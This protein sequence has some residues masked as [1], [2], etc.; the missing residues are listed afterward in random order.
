MYISQL[1]NTI[2]GTKDGKML[3]ILKKT[4]KEVEKEL[5]SRKT[6]EGKLEE[7]AKRDYKAE[8]KKYGSSTKSKKYRAELNKY[9]RKKGTYGNGDGKDASHKGGKI[10]GFEKESVNRGRREKSRLKKEQKLREVIRDILSEISV[11]SADWILKGVGKGGLKKIVD[12]SKKNKD[13]TYLVTDDNY[14]HIGN[15]YLRNGKFA[16]AKTWGNPNY[17]FQNNKTNLRA[18]SDVIYK[19]RVVSEDFAGAYPEHQ[20]KKFDGKRRKQSEILGYKLT[21]KSDVK[22][23]I[24]DATVNEARKYKVIDLRSDKGFKEAEKLQKQGWKVAEVGFHKI[25]MVKE[26]AGGMG[27]AKKGKQSHAN[28]RHKT[29]EKEI[30][31]VN[32]KSVLKKYAKIGFLPY[33]LKDKYKYGSLKWKAPKMKNGVVVEG[34]ITEKK[35]SAIDVA[36]RIVKDKQYEQGVDMQTANLI[37]KIYQ[38]YDKHPALQKKFE[39]MPL[40]KMAQNVWRFA[41]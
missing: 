7:K 13:K 19:V 22:A 29:S 26:G 4:K 15:F 39:K 37:L 38:A 23:E 25:Q 3:N 1:S 5:K 10:S 33:N 20:R 14:S 28:L 35:E 18:K 21:G 27:P 41:K 24:D 12:L 9:N 30:S 31:V 6:N 16:K 2:K 8:Y 40:K 17:D 36:K 11:K 32:S 34:N